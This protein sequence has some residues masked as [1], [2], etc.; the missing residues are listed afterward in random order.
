[1]SK[2]IWITSG[3]LVMTFILVAW[4]RFIEWYTF[5]F[6][7][8]YCIQ[9]LLFYLFIRRAWE[10][11]V[12]DENMTVE[13]CWKYA[14]ERLQRMEGANAGLAWEGGFNRRTEVKSYFDRTIGKFRQYR[15]FFATLASSNQYVLII[16]DTEAR[17]IARM[18]S[19]PSVEA[20]M[21]PWDDFDPF[22]QK[23]MEPMWGGGKSKKGNRVTL[24][25]GGGD[26][27]D[28][29]PPDEQVDRAY[30]QYQGNN[31][32]QNGRSNR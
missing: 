28:Y 24:N 17:D 21:N 6:S 32:G 26:D 12:V 5:A 20:V 25:F 10:N 7:F 30:N 4:L 1:M 3:L 22:N 27:E 14:N 29:G 23:N 11:D 19:V 31:G 9:F 2:L 18:Q 13:V 15:A 8:V 16:F